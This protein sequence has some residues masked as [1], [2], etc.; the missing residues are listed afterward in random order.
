[1][2]LTPFSI[3]FL[4]L[5]DSGI[6]GVVPESYCLNNTDSIPSRIIVGKCYDD[7]SPIF[8]TC[9]CCSSTMDR[10]AV[11]V[12]CVEAFSSEAINKLLD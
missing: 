2:F 4:N 3:E 12:E 6:F 9:T 7:I 1:L 5:I 11:T 10:P 8:P